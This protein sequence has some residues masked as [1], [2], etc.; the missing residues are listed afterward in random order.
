MAG[1]EQCPLEHERCV[2]VCRRF[3]KSPHWD[4]L[5]DLTL[6]GR[7]K[8]G[9]SAPDPGCVKTASRLGFPRDLQRGLDETLH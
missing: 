6:M 1:K 7:G 4:P 9:T 8:T 2:K 5:A 3:R